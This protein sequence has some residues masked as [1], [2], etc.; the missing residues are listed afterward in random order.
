MTPFELEDNYDYCDCGN[1][2]VSEQEQRDGICR[3]CI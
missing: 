2:L 3:D 1:L